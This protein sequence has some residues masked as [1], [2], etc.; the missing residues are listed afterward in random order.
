MNMKM[1]KNMD[2]VKKFIKKFPFLSTVFFFG[3][4]GILFSNTLGSLMSIL[5]VL[6][7]LVWLL[8]YTP[9]KF[10]SNIKNRKNE[11]KKDRDSWFFI[12]FKFLFYIFIV[13]LPLVSVGWFL[14]MQNQIDK[15]IK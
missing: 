5:V 8:I 4:V 11:K 7:F 14:A 1:K 6:V 9:F 2:N 12:V 13:T 3:V 10:F 15:L